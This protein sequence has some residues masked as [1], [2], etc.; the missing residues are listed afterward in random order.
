MR[1]IQVAL[2]ADL[3]ADIEVLAAEEMISRAA[4]V[5]RALRKVLKDQLYKYRPPV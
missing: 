2:P 4:W 1:L 5:R 3:I